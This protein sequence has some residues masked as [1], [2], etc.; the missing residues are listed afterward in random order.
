MSTLYTVATQSIFDLT[1]LTPTSFLMI[2]TLMII[3]YNTV[4]SLFFVPDDPKRRRR[5]VVVEFGEM[6]AAELREYDGSDERKPLLMGIKGN[7]YDVTS[8][9]MF[10][11]PGGPYSMFGGKDAS[12]ALARLSFKPQD[13]NGNLEGLDEAELEVL[14]DWEFKF[15]EKYPKVAVIVK[16]KTSPAGGQPQESKKTT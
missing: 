2:L 1:G 11:G 15:M 9:R 4:S 7:V 16:D 14:Q 6:T 13:L 10:Y 8:G 12:R 3:T 5:E